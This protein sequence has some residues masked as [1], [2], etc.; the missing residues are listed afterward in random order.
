MKSKLLLIVPNISQTGG[1]ERVINTLMNY[2][3]DKYNYEIEIVSLYSNRDCEC[4]FDYNKL[5][6]ITHCN[7]KG[8]NVNTIKDSI[9]SNYKV[10]MDIKEVLTS[11]DYDIVI[12]FTTDIS[13]AACINK[14][15]I[16]GKLVITEHSDYYYESKIRRILRALTY[17]NADKV[18]LLTKESVKEYSRFIKKKKI[19][20]IPNPVPFSSNNK[21][22]QNNNKIIW[23]GRLEGV[24]QLDH[25]I[26]IFNNV[27]KTNN[28]WKL[29]I[30]G[31]GSQQTI[32]QNMIKE[33]NLD[34]RVRI[35][36]FTK[37]VQESLLNSDILAITSKL[38]SFSMVILE[39]MECGVPV[40]SYNLR[41]PSE[42]IK[43]KEDGIIIEYGNKSSFTDE[44][45]KLIDDSDRRFMYGSLAKEN[46]KRYSVSNIAKI[47]DNMFN[48]LLTN[49]K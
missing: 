15:Y 3:I 5:I 34:N 13:T 17:K 20:I 48:E 9:M 28:S 7:K 25:L 11:K 14:K 12:T 47:W 38:E 42:I 31:C 39:A 8:I 32:L 2:I 30:I 4:S 22:E 19:K 44:L 24:K 27:S 16:T 36:P 21:S 45:I 41:G 46:V 37:N 23:L 43:D 6:K 26:E 40:I 1:V 49:T 33:Y 18:I 35:L 29:D 10:I